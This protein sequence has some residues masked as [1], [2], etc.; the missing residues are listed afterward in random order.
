MGA[1]P[2]LQPTTP[3]SVTELIEYRELHLQSLKKHLELAQNRMKT[4]AN[5]KRFNLQFQ[6]GDL[7]LLKLQLYTQ[8]S[9]ANRP[10]PKLSFKYFG[11]YKILER[12]GSVADH[13]ELPPDSKIHSVFHVSQLKPFIADYS[14]VYSELLVTTD[15]MQHSNT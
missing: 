12:V 1:A 8:S 6:V 15:I 10:F 4:M 5:K 2:D 13:L 7:A 14:P 11:P 3:L 9:I